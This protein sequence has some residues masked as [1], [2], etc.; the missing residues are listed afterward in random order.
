[1]CSTVVF[2]EEGGKAINPVKQVLVRVLYN[3]Q[4]IDRVPNRVPP[5]KEKRN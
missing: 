4:V 2:K 5:E 1:M 3:H